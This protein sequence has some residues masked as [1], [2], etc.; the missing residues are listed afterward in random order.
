MTRAAQL[1]RERVRLLLPVRRGAPAFQQGEDDDGRTAAV[2]ACCVQSKAEEQSS[3]FCEEA[4]V[5]G[6]GRWT[7]ARDA[8]HITTTLRGLN[9]PSHVAQSSSTSS[10]CCCCRM[11]AAPSR[12]APPP[13]PPANAKGGAGAA[14][15]P[16][17][18]PAGQAADTP[19]LDIFSFIDVNNSN[20]IEPDELTACLL[21][22]GTGCTYAQIKEIFDEL[23]RDSDGTIERREF[24]ETAFQ[25]RSRCIQ[26]LVLCCSVS[27]QRR[28]AQAVQ[29]IWQTR[30][31]AGA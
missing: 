4:V 26:V 21:V 22:E 16:P 8:R 13:R 29:R 19:L 10:C 14:A 24:Q 11:G 5:G 27:Q 17:Q 25:G 3:L 7:R 28:I 9:Y 6:R 23:D 2:S 31:E 30:R 18:P 1:G 20:T 15:A 12:V